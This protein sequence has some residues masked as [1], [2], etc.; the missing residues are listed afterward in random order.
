MQNNCHQCGHELKDD[1]RFEPVGA[2]TFEGF[3]CKN[4]VDA[5]KTFFKKHGETF[6]PKRKKR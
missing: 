6:I 1:E 2:K 5:S 4:C 3:Y